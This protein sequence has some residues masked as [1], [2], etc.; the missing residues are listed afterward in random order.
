MD[1]EK[2][3]ITIYKDI[4]Y[5]DSIE[6]LKEQLKKFDATIKATNEDELQIEI[7]KSKLEDFCNELDLDIDDITEEWDSY[8]PDES[9]DNASQQTSNIEAYVGKIDKDFDEFDA[10]DFLEN[11]RQNR[12][13]VSVRLKHDDAAYEAYI[14]FEEGKAYVEFWK[15]DLVND[16][17][18]MHCKSSLLFE[19]EFDDSDMSTWQEI[20]DKLSKWFDKKEEA[21][22]HEHKHHHEIKDKFPRPGFSVDEAL[23]L[24]AVEEASTLKELEDAISFISSLQDIDESTHRQ[25]DRIIAYKR[26]VLDKPHV[27]DAEYKYDEKLVEQIINEILEGANAD[28]PQ[29]IDYAISSRGGKVESMRIAPDS[30]HVKWNLKGFT[31]DNRIYLNNLDKDIALLA[32][33]IAHAIYKTSAKDAKDVHV[34][35]V[36]TTNMNDIASLCDLFDD[37]GIKYKL[38]NDALTVFCGPNQWKELSNRFNVLKGE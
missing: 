31:A 36:T 38:T 15:I 35:K 26:R 25:L 16:P 21:T 33:D 7:A 2:H 8:K 6:K 11:A 19:K 18:N 34:V 12:K 27:E 1:E 37:M 24:D 4:D 9:T 10:N 17:E 13:D 28:V 20:K 5:D 23:A 32:E 29:H 3:V 14:D 22:K 30:I